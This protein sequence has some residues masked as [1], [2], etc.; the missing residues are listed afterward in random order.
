[1]P[2]Q[3]TDSREHR[4]APLPTPA[5]RSAPRAAPSVGW[6]AVVLS[7]SS[8][9]RAGLLAMLPSCGVRVAAAVHHPEL[10]E[11]AVHASSAQLAVAAP[12]DGGD[13]VLFDTLAGLPQGCVALVLLATPGF[14]IQASTISRRF[15]LVCLPL[16]ADCDELKRGIRQALRHDGR[17]RVTEDRRT[18]MGA[19]LSEREQEV[20]CELAKG[21]CNRAIAETLWV[22]EDTV[23]S[24]LQRIY[25]KLGVK[26]RAA[27]VAIYIAQVGMA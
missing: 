10:L 17:R 8:L 11:E 2:G 24:H 27:A 15:D 12:G 25:R 19:L 5:Q 18:G 7:D 1:M 4:A 21:K 20:L 16:S 9:I 23:K 26:T 14:R 6:R 3:V 22:T 13:D